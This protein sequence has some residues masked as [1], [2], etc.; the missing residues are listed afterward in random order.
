VL[1][2][3]LRTQRILWWAL[4]VLIAYSRIYLGVHYP[5]DVIGGALLGY[6]C[7]AVAGR[8]VDATAFRT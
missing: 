4:A 2:R 5:F 7:G 6:G 1:A 8:V 3:R